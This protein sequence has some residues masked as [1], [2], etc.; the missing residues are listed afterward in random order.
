MGDW[1]VILD[2]KLDKGGRDAS[3]LDRCESSLIDLL[4]NHDLVSSGSP[5]VGDVDVTNR[6]AL[7]QDLNLSGQS[8]G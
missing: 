2:P 4:A 7:W 3:G 5:R 1:N 6:F 8:V